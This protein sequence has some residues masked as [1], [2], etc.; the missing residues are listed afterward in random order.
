MSGEQLTGSEVDISVESLVDG[1]TWIRPLRGD[2]LRVPKE[3]P[4]VSALKALC[5]S[6]IK[7]EL[8]VI[9]VEVIINNIPSSCRKDVCNFTFTD[10]ETP[11]VESVYPSEG[12]GGTTIYLSVSGFSDIASDVQ[13][14]IG[15]A[16]CEVTSVNDDTVECIAANHTAGIYNIR[17]KVEGKGMAV[18]NE[19]V[20]FRYL[21]S[22]DSVSPSSVGIGGGELITITG[23]GFMTFDKHDSID[24]GIELFSLPWFYHGIGLPDVRHIKYLN[25]CPQFERYLLEDK[26]LLSEFTPD[27]VVKAVQSIDSFE[28]LNRS[29]SD[30]KDLDLAYNGRFS[31]ESFHAHLFNVYLRFPAYVLVAGV[32]CVIVESTTSEISC[33]SVINLPQSANLSV[34]VLDENVHIENAFEVNTNQTVVI[35]SVVPTEGAVV[36]GTVLTITGYDFQAYS[37][38]DITAFIGME[39]CEVYSANSSHILCHTPASEPSLK[40]IYVLTP[41][42]VAVWKAALEEQLQRDAM[43]GSGSQMMMSGSDLPPLPIFTYKLNVRFDPTVPFR[44]SSFGGTLITLT[45]GIFVR[46]YTQVTVG[47]VL[48]EIDS[49]NEYEINFFTP[50]STRTHFVG[51]RHSQLKSKLL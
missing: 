24:F 23:N 50:T 40:P 30:G 1:G 17:A 3:R 16:P 13:V 12:Q 7:I 20:C 2:M 5:T 48:A 51:L 35:E 43:A 18:V 31:V 27:T 46:M 11:R 49:M 9:Q 10:E 28:P 38:E 19:S 44:G 29:A 45:G 36:G 22:V 21:L 41:A 14:Y 33:A 34:I 47:G 32:P 26:Y 42:G 39:K 8:Y 25:L 6:F 37:S 15:N 4:Q